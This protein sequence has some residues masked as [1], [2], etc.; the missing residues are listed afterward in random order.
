MEK[1]SP[2]TAEPAKDSN[3]YTQLLTSVLTSSVKSTK[4][5]WMGMVCWYSGLQ[6]TN[7]RSREIH[8]HALK[9]SLQ[10]L[11]L[12][13]L[14]LR[15]QKCDKTLKHGDV[16]LDKYDKPEGSWSSNSKRKKQSTTTT[17]NP[18]HMTF[19]LFYSPF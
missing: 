17:K 9:K 6:H 16:S 3:S 15:T 7:L 1:C 18:T 10:V 12:I 11:F 19:S 2:C 14:H 4:L 13:N 5:S 8:W